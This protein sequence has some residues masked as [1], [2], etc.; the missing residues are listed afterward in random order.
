[1]SDQSAASRPCEVFVHSVPHKDGL[2][3]RDTADWIYR[4]RIEG[5]SD[6]S[7]RTWLNELLRRGM[8]GLD[9]IDNPMYLDVLTNRLSYE[10]MER[11]LSAYYW[12]SGYGFQQV[13]LP[14]VLEM[15]GNPLWSSYIEGIVHEENT[16]RSH[17][18]IFRAFVE[19]VGCDVGTM[20]E[21]ARTF[22][23]AMLAGYRQN[24]GFAIGYALGIETEADFQ[25]SLI[26]VPF[27]ARFSE[28]MAETEF[29][30][31]HMSADGEEEHA[32]A[33]CR[34]I[35]TLLDAGMCQPTEIERGFTQAIVD[36]RDYMLDIR[37]AVKAG[38]ITGVS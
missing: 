17:C 11:F 35:E 5:R 3:V 6:P 34:T 15:E 9:H 1:M 4:Q 32:R 29:F 16:P 8:R 7:S 19:S 20:P 37:T 26:A 21:S 30:D 33:T 38:S 18:G 24:L 31:L 27:L 25:I 36:T 2:A 10:E 12:G 23:D 22:I 13:V 28:Q 14:V